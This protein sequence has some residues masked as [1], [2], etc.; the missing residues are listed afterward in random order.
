LVKGLRK[1]RFDLSIDFAGNDRGAA[2]S[3]LIGAKDRV[4][5]VDTK[6]N[7]LKRMAYTRTLEACQLPEVWVPR[8]LKMLSILLG[9]PEPSKLKTKITADP[10]LQKAAKVALHHHKVVC[11]IGTSQPK[12]EWPV[13]HWFNLYQKAK[14]AG[15]AIAFVSGTSPREKN[16][17]KELKAYAPEIYEL[18]PKDW[19]T[20]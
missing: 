14:Q 8:H 15:Y 12:K 1:E 2:L 18:R 3:L 7:F 17:M 11:H 6:P 13:K 16:L 10:Y 19:H 9:T 4:A 5:A 20:I